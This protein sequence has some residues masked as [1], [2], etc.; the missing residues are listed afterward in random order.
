MGASEA[1][2]LNGETLLKMGDLQSIKSQVDLIKE[3][4]KR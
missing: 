1:Q 4:C 2:E 3:H